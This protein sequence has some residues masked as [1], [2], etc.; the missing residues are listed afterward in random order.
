MGVTAP[1]FMASA[2]DLFKGRLFGLIYGIIEGFIGLGAA[3]GT[4][5]AGVIFD[6]TQSY[7]W[8]F[9]MAIIVFGL[10]SVFMW[11]AA[12]RRASV[13]LKPCFK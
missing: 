4:W 9:V 11:L 8:A 7:R 3:F 10:S 13:N 2:A 1:M 6:T 12:P 5:I